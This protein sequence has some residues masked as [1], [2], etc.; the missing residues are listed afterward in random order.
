MSNFVLEVIGYFT[1]KNIIYAID[2][3]TVIFT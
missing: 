2:S 1:D 3:F